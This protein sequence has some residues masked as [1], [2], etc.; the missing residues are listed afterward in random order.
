MSEAQLLADKYRAMYRAMIEKDTN[1]LSSLFS[2]DFVLEHMT[3]MRQDRESFFRY[4]KS[5]TLNYFSEE[6]C[7]YSAHIT[8]R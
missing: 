7:D 1:S 3:G 4:L 6:L 8:V 2:D 5:G